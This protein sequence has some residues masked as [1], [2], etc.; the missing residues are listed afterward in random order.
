MKGQKQREYYR[1]VYPDSYRPSLMM[2]I[3]NYEIED[4]SEYGIKLRVEED[5]AFMVN[6]NIMATIAFPDGREFDLS[7]HV[8]RVDQSCAGLVLDTPLPLSVIRSETLY[9]IANYPVLN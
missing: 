7:G 5:S 9:I 3:D 4:V 6:D 8:V 1:L 2:S